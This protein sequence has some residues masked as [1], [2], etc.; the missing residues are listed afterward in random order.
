MTISQE[1]RPLQVLIVGAGIAGLTAAIALGQQGHQVVVRQLLLYMHPLLK[2]VL[3]T[4]D[5]RKIQVCPGDGRRHPCASQLHCSA[6]LAV[7]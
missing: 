7:H 3:R 5:Y 1:S 4:A 6:K 2:D